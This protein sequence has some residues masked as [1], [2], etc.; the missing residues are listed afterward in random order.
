M[1]PALRTPWGGLL[2]GE[3]GRQHGEGGAPRSGNAEPPPS[4]APSSLRSLGGSEVTAR[5]RERGCPTKWPG[6]LAAAQCGV[7]E[8]PLHLN[9]SDIG[10]RYDL[11]DQ[12]QR[13]RVYEIILREGTPDDID[14]YIDGALLSDMWDELTLPAYIREA[15]AVIIPEGIRGKRSL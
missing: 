7:V 11:R 4:A 2:R 6:S 3:R 1:R 13:A 5:W 14:T 10:R 12:R 15:W 8:L 9:W